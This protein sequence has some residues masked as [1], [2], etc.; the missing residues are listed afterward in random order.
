DKL[1]LSDI[2]LMNTGTCEPV[3]NSYYSSYFALSDEL[4]TST[5]P[6]F[7]LANLGDTRLVTQAYVSEGAVVYPTTN[8]YDTSLET[9]CSPRAIDGTT[10][11]V[12]Q[13]TYEM[14][15][16]GN[17]FADDA[18]SVHVEYYIPSECYDYSLS[19]I[20]TW[21]DQSSC[22]TTEL[23]ALYSVEIHQSDTIYVIGPEGDCVE[24]PVQE[25][26]IYFKAG[27]ELDPSEILVELTLSEE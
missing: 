1:D 15:P 26:A 4:D 9:Y 25:N 22:G 20:A 14:G 16:N 17:W 24:E 11:C 18:C 13:G 2:H 27:D 6:S 12:P 5:L 21:S 10:Y 23:D 7:E 19:M 3:E 8:V